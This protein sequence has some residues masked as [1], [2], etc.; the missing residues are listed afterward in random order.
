MSPDTFKSTKDYIRDEFIIYMEPYVITNRGLKLRLLLFC[1]FLEGLN[2][3]YT[4]LVCRLS[5]SPL[6][7][8]AILIR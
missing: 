6:D 2:Y 3:K 7:L 1:L 5:S 8:V 4:A